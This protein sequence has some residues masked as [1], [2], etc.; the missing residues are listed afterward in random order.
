M[1]DIEVVYGLSHQQ[2]LYRLQ[3]PKGTTARQAVQQSPLA[4]DFPDA[5]L[6]APVGIFGKVVADDTVLHQHDRVE[7][8]RPLLADPK[9][10]RRKR[11]TPKAKKR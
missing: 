5:D 8:Y 6:N 11:V 1:L 3:C 4:Q 7:V 9:D 10:A 2:K